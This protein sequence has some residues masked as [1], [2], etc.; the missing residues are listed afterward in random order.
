[1]ND[2]IHIYVKIDATRWKKTIHSRSLLLSQLI[3]PYSEN[4]TLW[5]ES[6]NKRLKMIGV[7]P[8]G[9]LLNEMS[10]IFLANPSFIHFVK[11]ID[12]NKT[13]SFYTEDSLQ[14]QSQEVQKLVPITLDDSPDSFGIKI[15]GEET[16]FFS[17]CNYID[18]NCKNPIEY[19][20]SKEDGIYIGEMGYFYKDLTPLFIRL[21]ERITML[22]SYVK[23]FDNK[24]Q[25]QRHLETML[26]KIINKL[27][28]IL[29]G[30]NVSESLRMYLSLVKMNL[31][32]NDRSIIKELEVQ[33]EKN[34]PVR[35]LHG[36]GTWYQLED[37]KLSS[38][39]YQLLDYTPYRNEIHG[40]WKYNNLEGPCTI[41]KSN[42]DK[43]YF[44][45]CYLEKHNEL[46]SYSFYASIQKDNI[47][48][49]LKQDSKNTIFKSIKIDK[50][51]NRHTI[52]AL[53]RQEC[54]R[55][56]IQ[57]YTSSSNKDSNNY[58]YSCIS[59]LFR[60]VV[61]PISFIR[62]MDTLDTNNKNMYTS[63]NNENIKSLFTNSISSTNYYNEIITKVA[64]T[65]NGENYKDTIEVINLF[66]STVKKEYKDSFYGDTLLHLA[67]YLSSIDQEVSLEW[68]K[69]L[70]ENANLD[71]NTTDNSKRTIFH[72]LIYNSMDTFGNL[73]DDT[74]DLLSS[75]LKYDNIDINLTD[76][77]GLTL[78]HLVLM[79][80][81]ENIKDVLEAIFEK[82]PD[83][84]IKSNYPVE[85]TPFQIALLFE[86]DE[87][88]I[89]LI[90]SK[91][92]PE[93][94]EEQINKDILSHVDDLFNASTKD[95]EEVSKNIKVNYKKK[96]EEKIE[97]SEENKEENEIS[98]VRNATSYQDIL[99]II[100]S[101][102]EEKIK[103]VDS[104]ENTVGHAVLQNSFVKDNFDADKI[105]NIFYNLW[106]NKYNINSLDENND[107]PFLLLFT[108]IYKDT[109][110]KEV[111]KVAKVFLEDFEIDPDNTNEE[112][113]SALYIAIKNQDEEFVKLLLD[114]D[115]SISE[116]VLNISKD[117]ENEKIKRMI[118]ST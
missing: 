49:G 115:S 75:L 101:I 3:R 47:K 10:I 57:S 90:K 87:S 5:N 100:K 39:N 51:T 1:M 54:I 24:T 53:L 59:F 71:I 37:T 50:T 86:Q 93:D 64:C 11:K 13:I 116:E 69:T 46:I 82:N 62:S 8:S 36:V 107:S 76:D 67:V 70:L 108:T 35:Y 12:E 114:Y 73:I 95:K 45:V 27:D 110:K 89:E 52:E 94:F 21:K 91:L 19:N 32:Q 2:H 72:T 20:S 34:N 31:T 22:L 17:Y 33:L 7:M 85:A 23:D 25:D 88:I 41:L 77:N 104:S 44:K 29:N 66:D 26:P 118:Q 65:I 96:E 112:G 106:E 14:H 6:P 105:I 92:T 18:E 80:K 48:I 63:F 61:S 15:E 84:K 4:I 68:L 40:I 58:L 111:Y 28:L 38:S 9:E 103:D 79:V 109:T 56:L 81:F 30:R 74:G 113:V 83:L 42:N 97:I 43:I 117:T 78:L 98:R 55:Y 102:P 60:S 99:T 16:K